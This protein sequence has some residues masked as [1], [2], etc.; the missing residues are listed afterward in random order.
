MRS[1]IFVD[2][3]LFVEELINS[4]D[5]VTLI[6]MPR[7]WGKST[8]LSM[9]KTFLDVQIDQDGNKFKDKT[10]TLRYKLFAGGNITTK[11]GPSQQTMTIASTKLAGKSP[12]LLSYYQGEFPVVFLD[13]QNCFGR[14][15]AEIESNLSVMK[16]AT[17]EAF[18]YL[19]KSCVGFGGTK[20]GVQYRKL[21]QEYSPT[22]SFQ[23]AILHL[24]KLL[25]AHHGTKV[26]IL[27]DEY[28]AVVT[29]AYREFD[30]ESSKKVEH[31]F[32][33][34]YVC[35]FKGNHDLYK[36]V[37]TGVQ[38]ILKIGALSGLNNLAKFDIRN[39]KYSRYY[40]INGD[41]LKLI[42]DHF[43]IADPERILIKDWYNGYRENIGSVQDKILIDKYNIWSV[44]KYMNNKDNNIGFVSYWEKSVSIDFIANLLK[45]RFYKEK[46]QILVTGESITL[47]HLK[48]DF[49]AQ[50]FFRLQDM[51]DFGD[52]IEMDRNGF[53]VILSYLFIQGYLTQ[54]GDDPNEYRIPN[55]EMRDVFARYLMV[56][57][58]NSLN[59]DPTKLSDLSLILSKVFRTD[60]IEQIESI[61]TTEFAPPLNRLIRSLVFNTKELNAQ[62]NG[63]FVN[64]DLIHTL[65]NYVALQMTNSY[66][67]TEKCTTKLDFT[68]GNTDIVMVINNTGAIIDMTF[69]GGSNRAFMES[70]DY[71]K[72]IAHCGT[73][74]F[75]G[76]NVSDEL[77]VTLSG[78]IVQ[79]NATVCFEYP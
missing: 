17:V 3:T 35:L 22:L 32:I 67:A 51:I 27:V 57:Y 68:E 52:S 33:A 65:M 16:T 5:K 20:L 4:S 59:V 12:G 24:C 7:R 58:E 72:L 15:L 73:R 76:C 54:A 28:D 66:F 60:S 50:D 31:M 75:I 77:E 36:G 44:M 64:D 42:M 21:V 70:K 6:T 37:L 9:L 19:E 40:G 34:I 53:D 25:R 49:L 47:N 39:S 71:R 8:N 13:F 18:R 29:R 46:I 23:D 38:Y 45:R 10:T 11:E 43:S 74:V 79:N 48:E 26:W 62:D 78:E 61:I 63:L 2:K 41:E 14:N 1:S 69:R 30:R 55:R 56:S